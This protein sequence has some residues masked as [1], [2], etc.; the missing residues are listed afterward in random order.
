MEC[1]GTDRIGHAL[2]L[3]LHCCS[4]SVIRCWRIRQRRE[5]CYYTLRRRSLYH[6]PA[7]AKR[8]FTHFSDPRVLPATTCV[9]VFVC[10]CVCCNNL[11]YTSIIINFELI[12]LI[13][14]Q[15]PRSNVGLRVLLKGC[16]NL[17]DQPSRSQPQW[18]SVCVSMYVCVCVCVC[19]CLR[20]REIRGLGSPSG[21]WEWLSVGIVCWFQGS[22]TA[23]SAYQCLIKGR[24]TD[25]VA[26]SF[27]SHLNGNILSHADVAGA[28]C[29]DEQAGIVAVGVTVHWILQ[30]NFRLATGGATDGGLL[31]TII[32][33]NFITIMLTYFL[34]RTTLRKPCR[35][36]FSPGWQRK[37]HRSRLTL[38]SPTEWV[39][40]ILRPLA[41]STQQPITKATA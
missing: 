36:T 29:R 16:N 32:S 34:Q 33:V 4:R 21:Y 31:G 19:V 39:E 26:F 30:A 24:D 7:K 13:R 5:G 20:E 27:S 12:W 37:E 8:A 1:V 17:I 35:D 3:Y 10:V 9:V 2:C 22:V 40:F 14:N 15:T 11:A 38:R 25:N 18:M 28:G 6:R 23:C 41:V